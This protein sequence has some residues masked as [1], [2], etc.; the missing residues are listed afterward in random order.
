MLDLMVDPGHGG[1][2]PGAVG[3]TGVREK[4]IT[5]K[6]ALKVGNILT[7]QGV[8][9]GYTRT[10][11]VF[12][13]LNDRAAMANKADARCFLSIHINSASSAA[14][15]GTETYAYAAGGQGGKLSKA[16]QSNLVAA[17][18]LPDR[19]AKFA[20]FAVL[21]GTKMPAA[22]TEV[23]FLCN[24]NEEALLKDDAFLDK[25]AMGIAKGAASFLDITWKDSAPQQSQEPVAE[26]HWGA[27][28][29]RKL[30]E[31]NL[32]TGDH[33]PESKVSWA[34]FAAVIARVVE[35]GK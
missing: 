29:I 35:L 12:L 8:K 15:T 4:D 32:I 6:L 25:A 14:A 23:C 22:L 2:D 20:N 26:E 7:T 3:P 30:K 10:T 24:S 33:D 17:I 1:K 9:I 5:L 31:L 34:E 16:V 19:G 27:N 28:N 11:D 18:R 13:E 21:R